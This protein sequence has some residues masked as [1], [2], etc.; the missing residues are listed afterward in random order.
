[1]SIDSGPNTRGGIPSAGGTVAAATAR[2]WHSIALIRAP[3]SLG[4]IGLIT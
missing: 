4:L 3:I 2:G 1:M